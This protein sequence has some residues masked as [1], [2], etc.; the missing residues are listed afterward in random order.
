V[1]QGTFGVIQGMFSEICEPNVVSGLTMTTIS[2]IQGT[3]GMIQG[4][5]GAIQGMFSEICEPNVVSGSTR[6]SA[7]V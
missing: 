1:I 6:T 7:A 5:F 3:F 4:T 2:S